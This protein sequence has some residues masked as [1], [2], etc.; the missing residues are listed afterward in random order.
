MDGL[1]KQLMTDKSNLK[2]P[3]LRNRRG[4]GRERGSYVG[5][6]QG[7]RSGMSSV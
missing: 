3:S 7:R 4:G 5:R 1:S 2:P 6:G